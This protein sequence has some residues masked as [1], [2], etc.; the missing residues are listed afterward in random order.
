MSQFI[1]SN[2][3]MF[4]MFVM[5]VFFIGAASAGSDTTAFD[6]IWDEVSIWAVNAPGKI[7]AFLTFATAVFMGVV[8]QNYVAAVGAFF[9]SMLIANAQTVIEYFLTAGIE[10]VA[11]A[12]PVISAVAL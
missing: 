12:S 2:Q 6:S 9:A 10:V 3:A 1:K 5:S 7:V 8:Q 4:V 11:S